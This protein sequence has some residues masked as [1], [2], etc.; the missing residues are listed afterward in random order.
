MQFERARPA[1]KMA[2]AS[3]KREKKNKCHSIT[4]IFCNFYTL[5]EFNQI[6]FLKDN[7]ILLQNMSGICHKFKNIQA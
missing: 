4:P 1:Q 6:A 2:L 7:S 3:F 5:S